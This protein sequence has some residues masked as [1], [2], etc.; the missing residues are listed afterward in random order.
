MRPRAPESYPQSGPEITGSAV[1]VGI[2]VGAY[3]EL[4]VIPVYPVYYAPNTERSTQQRNRTSED[5]ERPLRPKS[6]L[7]ACSLQMPALSR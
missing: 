6:G 7:S 1:S 5:H 2:Y 3:P 4:D